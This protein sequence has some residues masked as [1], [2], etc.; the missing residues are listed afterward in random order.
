MTAERPPLMF[1]KRLGGL[2]AA[3]REA[4]AAVTGIAH[5]GKVVAKL[6]GASRNQ[7]RRA[8]YWVVVGVVVGIINDRDGTDWTEGELHDHV[9]RRLGYVT[10]LPMGSGEIE[11]LHSTSDK[12]MDETAR[13]LFT[14]RAF[15]AFAQWTGVPV[16][17][18][19]AE[20]REQE[21]A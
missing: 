1:V 4:E 17:T 21:A 9:R 5:G 11:R 13:A 8:L 15:A 14:T 10:R 2:Y 7:R 16:D 19:I 6:S 18:L 3:N 12:A 20:G